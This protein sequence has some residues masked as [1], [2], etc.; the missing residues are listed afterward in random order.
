MRK[1]RSWK[2][3]LPLA[4]LAA[5]AVIF[6]PDGLMGIWDRL[7]RSRGRFGGGTPE[8]ASVTRQAAPEASSP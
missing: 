2:L 4:A 1:V 7:W 6:S 5:V 3:V 8:G